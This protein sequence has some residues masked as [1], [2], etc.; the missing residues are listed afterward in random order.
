ME[1]THARRSARPLAKIAATVAVAVVAL[2]G[3]LSSSQNQDVTYINNTRAANGKGALSVDIAAANKAQAWSERMARTGVLEHT[4]GGSKLD[5][6]GVSGWCGYG[7]NVGKGPTLSGIHHSFM[8]SGPHK[9]NILGS[10]HRVGTG[11]FRDS[12]GI[13]W[14][15]EI[16]L[17]NC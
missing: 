17:R 7:E 3:C 2:S 16:Y 5:T 8:Q 11:V 9:A 12:S 14:V 10:W 13:V 15:T 1:A 4:G 6:T